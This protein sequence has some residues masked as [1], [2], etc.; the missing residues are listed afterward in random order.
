MEEQEILSKIICILLDYAKENN[1][2]INKNLNKVLFTT[3]ELFQCMRKNKI[4][5]IGVC[6]HSSTN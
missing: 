4:A 3:Q 5:I 1:Y 2:K 6:Q